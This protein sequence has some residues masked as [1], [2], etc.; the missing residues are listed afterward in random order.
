[1]S[2]I[3]QLSYPVT[4][5]NQHRFAK[6]LYNM[7]TLERS[8]TCTFNH[9]PALVYSFT[10]HSIYYLLLDAS[11]P[12]V[13]CAFLT[14]LLRAHFTTLSFTLLYLLYTPPFI[15]YYLYC[16]YMAILSHLHFK[17]A[18]HLSSLT[19]AIYKKPYIM[20]QKSRLWFSQPHIYHIYTTSL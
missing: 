12:P 5:P 11:L 1:M 20:L 7:R 4:I 2:C 3:S 10:I 15:L 16:L 13:S 9:F 17:L 14:F 19:S 18:T 8:F 6:T